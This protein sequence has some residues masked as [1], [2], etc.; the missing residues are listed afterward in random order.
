M[1][2]DLSRLVH[3]LCLLAVAAALVAPAD[4]Q[5]RGKKKKADDAA[6]EV[7][8]DSDA[9]WD[10]ATSLGDGYEASIDVTE[11]T[12]MSVDVSPDGQRLVFDLLGDLYLLPIEGGEAEALTSGPAWDMQP[13]WSPD[14]R[15]LVFNHRT[16]G[17]Y[18][19]FQKSAIGSGEPEQLTMY[20]L[21]T[22]PTSWSSAC[23]SES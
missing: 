4:A 22:A 11:G 6:T 23:R 12:W 8:G 18:N 9:K 16:G 19:V 20:E 7:N 21:N 15:H 3:S 14:G 10:V 1:R 13:V 17:N 2:A 5:R